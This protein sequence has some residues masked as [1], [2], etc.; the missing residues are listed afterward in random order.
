MRVALVHGILD[1]GRKFR[2]LQRHLEGLGHH[3]LA[4]SLK[5]SDG[6]HGLLPLAEQ[7][8]ATVDRTWGA[9]APFALV[10]FSMGGLISRLY[11][12]ELGGH[13]RVDRFF[14][15]AAP[16][17]GS[18]LAW[19]FWGDGARQ[20]RPGSPLLQRLDAGAGRLDGIRLYAYWTPFDAVIVPATSARW[21]LAESRRIPALCHPCMLWHPQLLADIA[22]RLDGTPRAAA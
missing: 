3:C 16:M 17:R 7:L 12:Q 19:T 11:L 13:A 8:A 21:A 10:G 1:T 14:A 20:M 5:P 2:R 18:L 6:R 9:D 4:P 22:R 15:I